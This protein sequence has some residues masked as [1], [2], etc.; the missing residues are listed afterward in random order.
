VSGK[1]ELKTPVVV[2]APPQTRAKFCP[3]LPGKKYCLEEKFG[4]HTDSRKFGRGDVNFHIPEESW[5]CAELYM[6]GIKTH[7]KQ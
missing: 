4:A 7:I 3:S 6:F 5:H 2:V 1:L